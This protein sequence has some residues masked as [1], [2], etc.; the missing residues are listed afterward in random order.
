MALAVIFV[1]IYL[2]IEY[3]LLQLSTLLF[4][5][6]FTYIY[7]QYNNSNVLDSYAMVYS[8][9][10][11]ATNLWLFIC[12]GL[13]LY[14]VMKFSRRFFATPLIDSLTQTYQQQLMGA[15]QLSSQTSEQDRRKFYAII[16]SSVFCCVINGLVWN[17][18]FNLL[19]SI[20]EV[21]VMISDY[22]VTIFIFSFV[23][24]GLN[25]IFLYYTSQ[26]FI[27]TRNWLPI[28]GLLTASGITVVLFSF[29]VMLVLFFI[30]PLFLAFNSIVILLVWFIICYV[31]L[32]FLTK[33]TLRRYLA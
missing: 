16:F 10:K 11:I 31:L 15:Q 27:R 21:K 24:L 12:I 17:F 9:I 7:H 33:F 25:Y 2:V 20:D 29:L 19:S 3:L 26:K 14:C 30:M 23:S 5:R 22:Y 18:C 4:L 32:Y 8:W 6:Q 28:S 13:I 1:I